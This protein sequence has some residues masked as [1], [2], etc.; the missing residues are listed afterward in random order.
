MTDPTS[1]PMPRRNWW[2]IALVSAIACAGFWFMPAEMT[3]ASTAFVISVVLGALAGVIA[4]YMTFQHKRQN[5]R[6][7]TALDNLSQGLCLFDRTEPLVLSNRKYLEMYGLSAQ[8]VK[9]GLS[10]NKLLEYR[11]SVG[12]FSRDIKDS[13]NELLPALHSGKSTGA[14]VRSADGRL[15]SVRNRP[16]KGGG[17]V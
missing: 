17:W 13:R 16:V 4:L 2:P 8:I 6:I 12:S 7:R 14:E 9:P 10:L 11:K 5:G 15:I 1:R 3:M